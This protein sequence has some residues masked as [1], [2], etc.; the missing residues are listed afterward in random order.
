MEIL[1]KEIRE[2]IVEELDHYCYICHKR[3]YLMCGTPQIKV[4]GCCCGVDWDKTRYVR[5]VYAHPSC[6]F[7]KK[8]KR[9]HTTIKE[10]ILK[11]IIGALAKER[12]TSL[13]KDLKTNEDIQRYPE[14]VADWKVNIKKYKLW[15]RELR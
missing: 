4:G 10:L 1:N 13:A 9:R 6:Y 7:S 8:I 15:L 11:K 12:I 14:L 3:F 2:E 5:A